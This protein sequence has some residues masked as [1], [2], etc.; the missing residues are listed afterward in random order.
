M[1]PRDIIGRLVLRLNPALPFINKW[2]CL[3]EPV[4]IS[5][6]WIQKGCRSAYIQ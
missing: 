6:K 4:S 1:D 3:S 5:V 2:L